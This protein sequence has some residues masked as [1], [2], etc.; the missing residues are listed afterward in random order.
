MTG[1]RYPKEDAPSNPIDVLSDRAVEFIK[2]IF[3]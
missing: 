2:S 1:K 3:G